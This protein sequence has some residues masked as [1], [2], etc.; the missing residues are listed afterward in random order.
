LSF[1]CRVICGYPLRRLH[2]SCLWC[3]ERRLR[4]GKLRPDRYHTNQYLFR[5]HLILPNSYKLY[6]L[7][8]DPD[9]V[10]KVYQIWADNY[11][12]FMKVKTI[13]LEESLKLIE[14]L[15]NWKTD[16]KKLKALLIH[17]VGIVAEGLAN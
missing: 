16:C 11:R 12:R 6:I 14:R 3:R 9:D 17:G 1:A 5:R 2:I 7:F 10:H 8:M 15:V 13:L 4:Y